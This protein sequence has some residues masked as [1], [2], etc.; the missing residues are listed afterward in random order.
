MTSHILVSIRVAATP[1]RTF[2]VFT[3]EIGEWWRP[4]ELFRFTHKSPGQLRFEPGLGGRLIEVLPDG[5][6]FEIGR[7][8]SW[9][10]GVRLAFP[11]RQET[12]KEGQLTHVQ[13]HF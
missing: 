3:R 7:I 1:A 12:F 5:G 11:W 6:V 9:E 2:D 4:N 13:V 10:P 8:T